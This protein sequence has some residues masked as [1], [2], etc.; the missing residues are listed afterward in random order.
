M[1]VLGWEEDGSRVLLRQRWHGWEHGWMPG[2]RQHHHSR[3]V[4]LPQ[5]SFS[6]PKKQV[7]G[8]KRVTGGKKGFSN[9]LVTKM[10]QK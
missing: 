3:E 6:A 7:Q 4:S 1:D 5:L 2:W 8:D 10:E 9:K